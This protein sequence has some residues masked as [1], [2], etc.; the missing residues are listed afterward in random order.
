M[1]QVDENTQGPFKLIYIESSRMWE[2]NLKIFF[3]LPTWLQIYDLF[4]FLHW[5]PLA[6]RAAWNTD[7][8]WGCTTHNGG[9]QNTLFVSYILVLGCCF[10]SNLGDKI[11]EWPLRGQCKKEKPKSPNKD[12]RTVCLRT[13][14][15]ITVATPS[16]IP[17]QSSPSQCQRVSLLFLKRITL[18]CHC[19]TRLIVPT[20]LVLHVLN[21]IC[22][23]L[24]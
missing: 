24:A 12:A 14:P 13:L 2:G 22:G 7:R 4:M 9:K 19:W 1:Q 6:A 10:F 20:G 11:I 17:I 8:E 5:K 23:V 21:R 16:Q 3:H 15:D 18:H